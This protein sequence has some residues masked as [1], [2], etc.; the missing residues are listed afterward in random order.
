MKTTTRAGHC[1]V[2]NDGDWYDNDDHDDND[3]SCYDDDNHDDDLQKGGGSGGA[4][5]RAGSGGRGGR[6]GGSGNGNGRQQSTKSSKNGG[7]SN[8]GGQE[9][10][11][12]RRE[13]A[14]AVGAAAAAGAVAAVVAAVAAMASGERPEVRVEIGVPR[15]LLGNYLAQSRAMFLVNAYLEGSQCSASRQTFICAADRYLSA[16]AD[17]KMDIIYVYLR[18]FAGSHRVLATTVDDWSGEPFLR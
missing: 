12:K 13:A 16:R 9:V 17:R 18:Y 11:G 14:A 6:G 4:E 3:G 1:V 2:V 15:I 10:P 5:N 7:G 8:S